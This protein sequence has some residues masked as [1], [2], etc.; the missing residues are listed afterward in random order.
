M[1]ADTRVKRRNRSG[2]DALSTIKGL[3]HLDAVSNLNSHRKRPMC[4]VIRAASPRDA[5]QAEDGGWTTASI[6]GAALP[7][8]PKLRRMGHM[9]SPLDIVLSSSA[10]N[11]EIL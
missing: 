7:Q 2:A 11:Y 5:N 8:T 1:A 6:P 9:S 4:S 10:S 3:R